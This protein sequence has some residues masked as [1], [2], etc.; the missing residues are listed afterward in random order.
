MRAG[1]LLKQSGFFV[2]AG[3]KNATVSAA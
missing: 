1:L 3:L 2:G